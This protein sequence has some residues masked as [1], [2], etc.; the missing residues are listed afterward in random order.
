VAL[1]SVATV[2]LRGPKRATA[3]RSATIT[4]NYFRLPA[5]KVDTGMVVPSL[6]LTTML[7]YVAT[8]K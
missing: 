4:A 6:E 7:W 2:K 3:V 8:T 1:S 5:K